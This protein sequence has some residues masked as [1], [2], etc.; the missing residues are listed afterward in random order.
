M[1]WLTKLFSRRRVYDELDKEIA[2]HIEEKIDELV[3]GGMPL[4][5]ATAAARRE[6]GNVESSG[7][8]LA[9]RGAGGGWRI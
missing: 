4:K 1:N 6:F 7:K 8:R 2:A 3:G 9:K 5:E